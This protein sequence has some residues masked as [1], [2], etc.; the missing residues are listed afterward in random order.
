MH[1]TR[2]CLTVVAILSAAPALAED[3][4]AEDPPRIDAETTAT[5]PVVAANQG[6]GVDAAHAYAVDNHTIVKL[7]KTTGQEVARWEGG[8]DGPILH[9]DSALLLDG[10]LYAAHSNYPDWP[11]TSSVEIWNAET[12]EHVDTHSFGIDRGSLTWLD[13]HDGFWWA[14]F[15]NYN[16]LFD[17]SSVSYGNKWNT[18][19]VKLDDR[20]RVIEAWT[21]PPA[22]IES[23]EDMSNSGGSWGPDGRLY[24]SGHD[25]PEVYAMELPTAGSELVWVGT[26]A[27][28]STGQGF[29][30][31]RSAETPTIFA[32]IRGEEDGDN[33]VTVNTVDLSTAPWVAEN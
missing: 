13:R 6:V 17:R 14:T 24:I 18:Q 20:F 12:M 1:K 10:R 16:R 29:A 15:A 23:F 30:W 21:F 32:M 3:P 4:L 25:K 22:L 5:W 27:V 2:L 31:D 11:M 19:M 26:I 8:E 9:L 7:D 33:R 28:S